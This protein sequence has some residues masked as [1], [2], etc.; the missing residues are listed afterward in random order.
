MTQDARPTRKDAEVDFTARVLAV[1]LGNQ[2]TYTQW[3]DEV[4]K[5]TP[6]KKDRRTGEIKPGISESKFRG[7]RRVLLEQGRVIQLS[8]GQ[9]GI[10][11]VVGGLWAVFGVNG[12]AILDTRTAPQ[13]TAN[14][15]FRSRD[16]RADELARLKQQ[17]R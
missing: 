2:A 15:E 1:R 12:S 14:P 4:V 11:S 3:F 7:H 9:D 17:L 5:A 10:Y 6:P 16:T 13:S 8:T